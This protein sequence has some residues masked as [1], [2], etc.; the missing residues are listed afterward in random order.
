MEQRQITDGSTPQWRKFQ[1]HIPVRWFEIMVF[2]ALGHLDSGYSIK[3]HNTGT[4]KINH[5]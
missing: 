1:C 3:Q 5:A 2:A 4:I